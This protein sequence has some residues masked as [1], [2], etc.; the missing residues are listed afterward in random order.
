MAAVRREVGR[1]WAPPNPDPTAPPP[2]S[3]GAAVDLTLADRCG[4]PVAM[5]SAIDAIGAVSAPDHFQHV[6]AACSDAGERDQALLFHGHRRLLQEAMH[7]A[8][9]AQHPAEWWHFSWGDQ[10]WAWRRG[11]PRAVYGRVGP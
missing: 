1:F 2:H 4:R 8:G 11:Q 6:A 7:A 9:F 10:L 3:T 5:G